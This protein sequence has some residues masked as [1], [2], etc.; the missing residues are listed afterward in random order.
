MQILQR[1]K[2]CGAGLHDALM[3]ALRTPESA[4][5]GSGESF[6]AKKGR[7]KDERPKSREETPEVGNGSAGKSPR[8]TAFE[9]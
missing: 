3:P 1:C 9:I 5:I 4:E 6:G 8:G 7:S 2:N